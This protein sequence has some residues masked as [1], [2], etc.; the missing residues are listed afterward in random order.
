MVATMMRQ[1]GD[2]ELRRTT[3]AENHA[4]PSA[5]RPDPGLF[6]LVIPLFEHWTWRRLPFPLQPHLLATEWKQ[7]SLLLSGV[8]RNV[9]YDWKCVQFA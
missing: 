2:R 4:G 6:A 7:E 3:G 8:S 9:R 1:T 5:S